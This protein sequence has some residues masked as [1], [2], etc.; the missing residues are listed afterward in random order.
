MNK[1]EPEIKLPFF[2]IEFIVLI[3]AGV[4]EKVYFTAGSRLMHL[5]SEYSRTWENL[6]RGSADFALFATEPLLKRR[7][8]QSRKHTGVWI[9]IWII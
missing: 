4:L 5:Q 7:P 2:D 1:L 3:I 8:N 9:S 6:N